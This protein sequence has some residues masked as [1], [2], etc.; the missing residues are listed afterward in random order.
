MPLEV[1]ANTVTAQQKVLTSNCYFLALFPRLHFCCGLDL[2]MRLGEM[3]FLVFGSVPWCALRLSGHF[4]QKPLPHGTS[5]FLR[6]QLIQCH[7]KLWL[8]IQTFASSGR[9]FWAKSRPS[10]LTTFAISS[11]AFWAFFVAA[12][13]RSLL[14]LTLRVQIESPASHFRSKMC[15]WVN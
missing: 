11:I 4:I 2:L 7:S 1:L 13:P 15:H 3:Q 8:A 10:I 6:R 5:L 12:T 9:C 14:P